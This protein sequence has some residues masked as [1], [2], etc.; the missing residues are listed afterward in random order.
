M[1]F[2]TTAT[3]LAALDLL[4]LLFVALQARWLFGGAGVIE[5]TTGLTVSEYAR[6]GFFEL[7]T[8]AVKVSKEPSYG[9]GGAMGPAQ[10]I[11]S[12]WLG[13]EAE[14]IRITGHQPVN[15][16]N[17]QDAFTASAIKLANGGA[18]SKDRAG[19]LR[20]AKAYISGNGS[21]SSATCN[22]YANTIQ[23]KA[24]DIEKNL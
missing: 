18:T 10:F 7:V 24:A 6:R 23:Q 21:C 1:R 11:P 5:A 3:V 9:C 16:W 14:V 8:A 13:Y 2:T 19:E 4:F 12:T 15:P 22:S 20:A 17:F